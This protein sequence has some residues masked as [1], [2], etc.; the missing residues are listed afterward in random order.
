MVCSDGA[1]ARDCSA[2]SVYASASGRQVRLRSLR[3]LRRDG[4]VYAHYVSFDATGPPLA[5]APSTS[6]AAAS[7]AT[8]L[9]PH[10]H[11]LPAA[12]RAQGPATI[13]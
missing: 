1:A 4:S 9:L 2:W 6:P 13:E 12:S 8:P 3:E 10:K 5:K 11:R 7:E